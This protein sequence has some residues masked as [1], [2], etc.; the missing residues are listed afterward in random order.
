MLIEATDAGL[1]CG[2]S[3]C[4]CSSLRGGRGQRCGRRVQC[5]QPRCD[6]TWQAPLL[7]WTGRSGQGRRAPYRTKKRSTEAKP[8]RT[9]QH[10]KK[11]T[12]RRQNR[13]PRGERARRARTGTRMP[14]ARA[15]SKKPRPNG[16]KQPP[17]PRAPHHR[18]HLPN[19]THKQSRRR[20]GCSFA[21]ASQRHLGSSGHFRF[22]CS[23]HGPRDLHLRITR[24][25]T[26][27]SSA[28]HLSDSDRFT[29]TA[30]GFHRP[31]F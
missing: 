16:K 5:A 8:R 15:S 14:G 7:S 1:R 27:G 21:R 10:K 18:T 22:S 23:I 4:G 9:L 13:G 26:S 6:R 31:H 24:T 28:S 2:S 29:C 12:A 11:W 25:G 20:R 3:G 30:S 17:G 19:R